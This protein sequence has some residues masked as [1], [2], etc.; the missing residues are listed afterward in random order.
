MENLIFHIRPATIK[1][2]NKIV[3]FYSKE[4]LPTRCFRL[5]KDTLEFYLS[6]NEVKFPTRVLI[7]IHKKQ[8]IALAITRFRLTY[9]AYE[10]ECTTKKQFRHQGVGFNLIHHSINTYKNNG[11][12]PFIAN[13]L[14]D[15]LNSIKLVEKLGFKLNKT[16]HSDTLLTY[17]LF[18]NE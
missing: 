13:V 11:Y 17:Y 10:I 3:N 9:N 18:R 7:A 6:S 5:I 2:L 16:S 1:D 14:P 8:I 12:P 15:N 4:A